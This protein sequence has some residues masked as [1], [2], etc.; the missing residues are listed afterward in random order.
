MEPNPIGLF[1]R[2]PKPPDWLDVVDEFP[3]TGAFDPDPNIGA[4]DADP[5]TGVFAPKILEVCGVVVALEVVVVV[6]DS[7][8]LFGANEK[9]PVFAFDIPKDVFA[10]AL[11]LLVPS[12]SS[13]LF[14][15]LSFLSAEIGIVDPNGVVNI[16]TPSA[17]GSPV[18]LLVPKGVDADPKID[19]FTGVDVAADAEAPNE[20]EEVESNSLVAF[21]LSPIPLPNTELDPNGTVGGFLDNFTSGEQMELPSKG[22]DSSLFFAF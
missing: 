3:K 8:G 5:K 4:F 18:L 20:K 21:V 12:L 7:K 17:D 1:A 11:I 10:N 9:D 15:I 22:N 13:V 19:I 6:V 16:F 2:A 14:S